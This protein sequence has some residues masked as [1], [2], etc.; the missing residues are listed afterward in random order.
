MKKIYVILLGLV[1]LGITPVFANEKVNV[2]FSKCVDGDTFKF[3]LKGTEQ[4]ARFLAI[5][6]PETVHPSKGEEPIKK[7]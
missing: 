6:T 7:C 2:E 4:T 1:I 5:D 3:V